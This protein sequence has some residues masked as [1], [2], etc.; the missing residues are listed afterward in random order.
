[1]VRTPLVR[2]AVLFV[3]CLATALPYAAA[4]RSGPVA[5]VGLFHVGLDHDPPGL[6]PLLESLKRLGYEEGSSI[7]S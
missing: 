7:A 5:R 2:L 6:G 4:Q 3:G 1:V